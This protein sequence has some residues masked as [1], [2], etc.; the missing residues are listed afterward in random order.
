M[1]ENEQKTMDRCWEGIGVWGQEMPRCP[2]LDHVIH[3][4]NCKVYIQAGRS[5][6]E[7]NLPDDYR[8][9][10]TEV[11]ADKKDT[12]LPGTVSVVIFRIASEWFA[13]PTRIFAEVIEP[14][15]TH[16]V[17]H[18]KNSVLIGI[19]N[20]HGEIQLCVSLSALFEFEKKGG[21]EVEGLRRMLVI[22][23]DG[24]KWVFAVDHIH[25]IHRVNPDMLQ[26][27][28]ATVSKA[29]STFT[30]ALFQWED[31]QVCLLDEELLIYRLTR[32]VQ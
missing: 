20:V 1:K 8:R 11:L 26:N 25:G 4:R 3:C 30:K 6:L 9:E 5:L 32:S 17:P 16:S 18:R 31:R 7:Q 24:E 19:I 21:E 12:Q 28:P 13:L 22:D 23:K 14:V 2:E 27:V 15:A 29:K 10:C